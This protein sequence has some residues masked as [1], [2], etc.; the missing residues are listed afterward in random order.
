MNTTKPSSAISR[1][2]V[3]S[4]GAS[5]I[6]LA[7]TAA[8]A[9]VAHAQHINPDAELLRRAEAAIEA[10]YEL[11]E[12]NELVSAF[13]KQLAKD[14]G[15]P[16][17]PTHSITRDNPEL[18]LQMWRARNFYIAQAEYA[19]PGQ[20]KARRNFEM[21][22]NVFGKAANRVFGLQANTMPGALAKLRVA[23]MALD[24]HMY[25]AWIDGAET[26]WL[27]DAIDDIERLGRLS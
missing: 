7:G 11:A 4:G 1:R 9:N 10:G 20:R 3:L 26:A 16:P 21:A 5:V 15:C 17:E 8:V 18:S 23:R 25:T 22:S 12:I 19:K 2:T 14:Y 27:D 13:C 24:D 6:A